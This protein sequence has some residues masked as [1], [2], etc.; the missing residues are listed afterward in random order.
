MCHDLPSKCKKNPKCADKNQI[1]FILNI[2]TQEIINKMTKI[3]KPSLP[4]QTAPAKPVRQLRIKE[5][6]LTSLSFKLASQ[7]K[8]HALIKASL[9]V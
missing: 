4:D 6:Q 8:Y 9:D 1:L 7:K 3:L 2:Q 5:L